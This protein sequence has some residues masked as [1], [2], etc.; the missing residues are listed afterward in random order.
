MTDERITDILV[1]Q[2]NEDVTLTLK[3]HEI[4]RLAQILSLRLEVS[5]CRVQS[6]Y[7]RSIWE[8]LVTLDGA[9]V[10]EPVQEVI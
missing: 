9:K 1:K 3:R 2:M 8:K 5:T 4:I 7:E 10:V 6:E